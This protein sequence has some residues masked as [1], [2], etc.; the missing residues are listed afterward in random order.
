MREVASERSGGG[1]GRRRRSRYVK[2]GEG[3]RGNTNRSLG[4]NVFCK[5]RHGVCYRNNNNPAPS[6]HN[7][8]QAVSSSKR[9]V[10]KERGG[11]GEEVVAV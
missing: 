3:G 9:E 4:A 8:S 10:A 5:K 11:K 2:G 6:T 1:R 7:Q